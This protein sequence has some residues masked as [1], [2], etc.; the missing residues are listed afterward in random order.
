VTVGKQ[1]IVV[2]GSGDFRALTD[3]LSAAFVRQLGAGTPE[4]AAL[5]QFGHENVR[6]VEEAGAEDAEF[7][8]ADDL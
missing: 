8:I 1:N 2:L 4:E 6:S 7:D 5:E 3:S